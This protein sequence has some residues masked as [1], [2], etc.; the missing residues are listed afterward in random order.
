MSVRP[1]VQTEVMSE[2]AKRH[3]W[4]EVAAGATWGAL[5]GLV[6]MLSAVAAENPKDAVAVAAVVVPTLLTV[7]AS[8][9]AVRGP[10]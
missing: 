6:W 7:V 8:A 10:P 9:V 4:R 2:K 1:A 3:G 5:G